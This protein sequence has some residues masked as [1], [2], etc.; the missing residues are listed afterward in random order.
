M[1]A[2]QRGLAAT[3]IAIM[4]AIFYASSSL[5]S[6][7][8][9]RLADKSGKPGQMMTVGIILLSLGLLGFYFSIAYAQGIV[10]TVSVSLSAFLAGFGSSFYHPIG[11]AII[12]SKFEPKRTG[13]ALG[14]NGAV[15][16]LGRMLY[17][18][19]FFLIAAFLT[20]FGSIA[21]FASIGLAASLV[22]WRG[23]GSNSCG[24][25]T[26]LKPS[27]NATKASQAIT[28]GIVALSLVTFVRSAAFQG[29][30]AWIPIY[31]SLAKGIGITNNLG[32]ILTTMYAAPIVGQPVFGKLIDKFDKRLLLGVSGAASA[33]SVLGY[34]MTS[35][36]VSMAFL[37]SF[38]FFT[39]SGFPLLMSLASDYVPRGS[40]SLGN[41]LVFGLGSN[42]GSVLGPL[43]TGAIILNNYARL[44]LAFQVM[45]V[46]GLVSAF[47]TILIPKA[48]KSSKMPIFG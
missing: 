45:V 9:G 28:R 21:F 5:L 20:K 25:Q 38:G 27:E 44:D 19:V 2:A 7:Y 6:M 1:L 12:Q 4:F 43:L 31:V 22:I 29:V 10:L 35:G 3:T 37:L 30:I 16:S 8:V 46:I 13:T 26:S 47:A 24:Y 18:A 17:P 40:S 23:C 14:I 41:A 34:M 42:A 36:F 48:T 39:F 11:A 32:I 33:M 15:G